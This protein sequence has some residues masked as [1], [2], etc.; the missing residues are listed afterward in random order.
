MHPNSA[1]CSLRGCDLNTCPDKLFPAL[2]EPA[3]KELE[4]LGTAL[5]TTFPLRG[6]HL[7]ELPYAVRD[8]SRDLTEGREE[9]KKNYMDE[10]RP[11][12]AYLHYFMPWNVYRLSRLFTGLMIDVPENGTVVDLGSGPLTAPIALWLSRPELREKKLTFFC[13]DKSN[14][15]LK[16]GLALFKT[17]GGTW[18]IN[19]IKGTMTSG[20]RERADLIIAANAFNELNWREYETMS[21]KLASMLTRV[22]ND[23]GRVLLVEPG[24]RH[25]TRAV[26]TLR[27]ALME[28]RLVPHAPCPHMVDCPMPGIGEGMWCHFR[29][30]ATGCPQWLYDLTKKA[31]LSKTGLSMSF[32]LMGTEEGCPDDLVRTTSEPFSIADGQGQYACS[33]KGLVMLSY[34]KGERTLFPGMLMPVTWPIREKIDYKSK[35][36]IIMVPPKSHGDAPRRDESPGKSK[37]D[38]GPRQGDRNRGKIDRR[39]SGKPGSK[40]KSSGR[41]KK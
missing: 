11:R 36:R 32:V 1:T 27:E 6:K 26:T 29:F 24:T 38:D 4:R 30:N 8:L 2:P 33:G 25:G 16:D 14:R 20:V 15:T 12:A 9:M 7:K 40:P 23:N 13:L 39:R 31:R 21:H 41:P 28:R 18:K 22:L 3:V 5:K 17:L 37:R 35:A 10:A 34:K 19:T